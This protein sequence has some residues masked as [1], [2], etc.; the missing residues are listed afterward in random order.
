MKSGPHD[1]ANYHS[2]SPGQKAAATRRANAERKATYALVKPRPSVDPQADAI[3][4][5]VVRDGQFRT[6]G[7]LTPD[8]RN[9]RKHGER[10]IATLEKSLEAFGAARSIVVDE[11]GRILAG[12][13]VVEAA[14]NVGIERVLQVEA[15]GNQI[16]AVV[17][18]GLTEAQ[19]LG[20]AVADNRVAELAEWD[21]KMLEGIGAEIDLSNFFTE[22]EL[23][24]V[25]KDMERLRETERTL[26][27]K[28]YVR[29]LV[30]VPLDHA[31]E[32]K[33]VLDQLAA[34]P[35][36]EIDYSAN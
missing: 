33:S 23:G 34:V 12:N 19:K 32:A 31:A 22:D 10:N 9:A 27:P 1:L 24:E 26:A 2:G 11:T 30:S 5:E 13:G 25:L 18:R 35:E 21:A 15:D 17:R 8:K 7:D 20:L 4:G 36:I 29:V 3:E 14:A 16:V 6:I 28:Q